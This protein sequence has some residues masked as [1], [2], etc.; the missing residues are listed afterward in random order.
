MCNHYTDYSKCYIQYYG[1]KQVCLA[2]PQCFPEY[3]DI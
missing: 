3:I 1:D 2:F